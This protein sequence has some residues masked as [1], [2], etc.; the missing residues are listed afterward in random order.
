[1]LLGVMQVRKSTIFAP[2][3]RAIL[4][5]TGVGL[6]VTGS[7]TGVWLGV[8]GGAGVLVGGVELRDGGAVVGVAPLLLQPAASA[9]PSSAVVTGRHAPCACLPGLLRRIGDRRLGSALSAR[10]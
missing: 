6:G 10:R 2:A 3:G 9:S 8:V 4:R 1:M 5:S 7:A